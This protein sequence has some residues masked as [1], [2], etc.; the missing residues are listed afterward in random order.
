MSDKRE[1]HEKN[2]ISQEHIKVYIDMNYEEHWRVSI[3]KYFWLFS[4]NGQ[5]CTTKILEF[6]K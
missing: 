3:Q 1:I 6:L 2:V 5:Y 4:L